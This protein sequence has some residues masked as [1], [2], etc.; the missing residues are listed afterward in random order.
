MKLR[1]LA[2]LADESV[3]PDVAAHLRSLGW[4]VSTAATM[5]LLGRSDAEILRAA[6]VTNVLC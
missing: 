2:Y 1:E 6:F 3:D 4:D 5:S